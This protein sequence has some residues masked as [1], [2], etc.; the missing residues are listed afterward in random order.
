MRRLPRSPS[1]GVA[2]RRSWSRTPG[3]MHI[4]GSIG[5]EIVAAGSLFVAGGVGWQSWASVVP[6]ARGRGIQRAL[7]DARSRLAAEQGCDL[8]AAWAL[9]GAHSS[10]NLERAGLAR[11]GRRVVVRSSDLR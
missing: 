6:A 10:A 8:V 5:G 7:I 9:A 4:T 3:W 2:W 1:C 11:I